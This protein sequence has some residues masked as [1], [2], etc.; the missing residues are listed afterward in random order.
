VS[1]VRDVGAVSAMPFLNTTGGSS[2]PIVIEGQSTPAPGSEP[3]ALL[4][5]ATPGYFSAMRIPLLE[6]RTFDAHDDAN[7]APVALISSKFAQRHWRTG[8]PV[9]QRIRLQQQ[10]NAITAEIIGVVGDVRHDALDRPATL[11]IFVPHAQ[12]PFT[13]MTFVA[14]TSG[15]PNA[16][17]P[18]LKSRIYAAAPG[19]PVYR[20]AVVQ[21]LIA[22]TLNDR[23]FM[24][25]LVV[26][27][28]ILAVALAASGVYGVMSLVSTQR[29]KEFGLRLAL[30]AER[31]EILG[32]V[33]RQGVVL[34]STGTAIGLL[35]ALAV[36]QLLRRFL[37]GIGP[38]DVLTLAVVCA[39]LGTVAAI[40]CLLPA[41]RATRVSPIVALRTE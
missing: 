40:A 17:L 37:F 4:T 13:G 7:R 20:T 21:D 19:R 24:L 18:E 11:E 35:G 28:A 32:M 25:T 2:V 10:G 36:G 14:R 22:T 30:G 41:L 5:V 23:R 38:N 33:M 31:G 15:D 12:L 34:T 1:Q 39:A 27:F 26:A 8:S 6:G 9:G 3:S 16:V 29:T